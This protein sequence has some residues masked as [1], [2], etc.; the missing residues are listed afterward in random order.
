MIRS[1]TAGGIRS[2]MRHDEASTGTLLGAPI[3]L[4]LD[5]LPRW[6]V[7]VDAVL[8]RA[9]LTR[10]ALSEPGARV[11]ADCEHRLWQAIEAE[12]GDVAIGL[13]IG[14]QFVRDGL[15]SLE[16]YLSRNSA[17]LRSALENLDCVARVAD[18]RLRVLLSERADQAT[19]RTL[20]EGAPDRA[21]GF[22]ECLFAIMVG[23][24]HRYVASV[25]LIEVHLQR[26]R[27]KPAVV[28][29]YYAA[30]GVVPRFG[31]QHSELVFPRG[32][33]ELPV[34]GAES[35]LAVILHSYAAQLVA[36]APPEDPFVQRVRSSLVRELDAGPIDLASVAR[37]LGSSERTL[38]R[39]L[40]ARGTSYKTL[41]DEV[42]RDLACCQLSRGT[43]LS[44]IAERL[45][46]HG[47]RALHKAF[48]RWT[49]LSPSQ[50]RQQSLSQI[51]RR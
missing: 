46:F 5:F 38:R 20:R 21:P 13:R 4:G 42:R 14:Q 34:H 45:G 39:Q 32:A 37:K 30:F 2:T 28:R 31:R 11:A 25:N 8:A 27:P 50:Y 47:S 24:V 40:Q 16:G 29:R 10:A 3:L 43:S 17:T 44:E 7:R 19:I 26:P 23:F 41:V 12:A 18:D 48:V 35:E 36:Q 6:D 33:L 49:S 22:T 15:P 1:G 9:N 51:E